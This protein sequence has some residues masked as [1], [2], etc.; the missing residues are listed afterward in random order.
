MRRLLL[1]AALV[2]ATLVAALPAQGA[3]VRVQRFSGFQNVTVASTQKPYVLRL[4]YTVPS[5]WRRRGRANGL[6]RSFGPI[7]SCAFTVR[8]SARA[9]TAPDAP[10]ATHLEPLLTTGAR[11][12]DSGERNSF[13]WV[14]VRP[15]GSSAVTGVLARRAP[16]V[17]TQ[18]TGGRVWLEVRFAATPNP[19]R[20]CHAGGPRTIATQI[21]DALATT[22][23]GGFEPVPR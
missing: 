16:S 11:R 8:V 15:R 1:A 6:S 2:I 17:R 23:V 5:T 10:A 14:V 7:G 9:T 18:P 21:G 13:A 22:A 20:E 3:T 12:A 4:R 19:R